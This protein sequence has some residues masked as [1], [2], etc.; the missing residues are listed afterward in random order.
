[1]TTL[2]QGA[3]AGAAA[4]AAGTTA[5]NTVGYLDMVVRARPASST[6]EVTVE[7]LSEAVHVQVPGDRKEREN[8]TA[9]LGPLTGIAAGVGMGVALGV[10]RAAGWRPSTAVTYVVAGVGALIGTN[11]PM[12]VLKVTDPRTWALKDW[13]ADIVPHAAYAAVTVAVVE[14]L[15]P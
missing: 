12:T 5:L 3:L 1:M 11:G 14:G 4:G 8:R 6:P 15:D 7:K 2:L 9:G 13:I 10:A